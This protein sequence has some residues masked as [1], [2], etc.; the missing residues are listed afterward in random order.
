MLEKPTSNNKLK[1]KLALKLNS[2]NDKK[3]RYESHKS[4]VTKCQKEKV[5]LQGLSIYVEPSIGNQDSEFLETWHER[6]QF[7]SL[8]LM[9]GP[10]KVL[11]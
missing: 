7:F 1:E 11:R 10:N 6:L 8:P 4:F 5:I 2:L 3:T 9:S